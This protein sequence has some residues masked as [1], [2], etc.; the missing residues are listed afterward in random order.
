MLFLKSYLNI[1]FENEYF[2]IVCLILILYLVKNK[3]LICQSNRKCWDRWIVKHAFK[4]LST[5]INSNYL[6]RI[7]SWVFLCVLCALER[8]KR[9]GGK[10]IFL[11]MQLYINHSLAAG[12]LES[13]EDTEKVTLLLNLAFWQ[14]L[15][16]N[17][18]VM[19]N[20][21]KGHGKFGRY[22]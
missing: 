7:F 3:K 14:S 22:V 6:K 1:H 9:V 20:I 4:V 19:Y 5:Y 17:E 11:S 15:I 16:A 8:A 10:I 21:A 13:T 2:I 18:I 12:S